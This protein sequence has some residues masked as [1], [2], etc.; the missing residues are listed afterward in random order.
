M[1]KSKAAFYAGAVF[2]LAIALAFPA[3]GAGED[4]DVRRISKEDVRK[5]LGSPDVTIIDLRYE[6]NWEKSDR[7]VLGAVREDP[8]EISSWTKKY[9]KD[10]MLVLYCD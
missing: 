7:K 3:S 1:T 6:K 8:N 9:P 5:L 4:D 10:R 2:L